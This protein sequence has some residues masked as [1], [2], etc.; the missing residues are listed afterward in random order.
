MTRSVAFADPGRWVPFDGERCTPFVTTRI[1][2]AHVHRYLATLDIARGKR[3]L[4]IACGEGYGAAML[5][6]N[7]AKAVT[8]ADLDAATVA[9][10]GEVYAHPG[11]DF[12]QADITCPLP[13]ADDAFDLVVSFET[14]E[15]VEAQAAFLDEV[16]RVLTPNGT[17]LCSTPDTR[18]SDPST[19]NPFHQKELTEDEFIELLSGRFAHVTRQYQGYVLGSVISGSGEEAHHWQRRGFLDYEEDGGAAQRF[20]ILACASN[21][22]ERFLPNGLLHD[23]AIV[24]TL[25][26]RIAELEARVA[27]LQKAEETI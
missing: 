21:A 9:R 14:I 10:A 26:K 17:F 4:D 24:S 15:H 19:P 7:G 23:G 27:E 13:F 16:A 25:N 11:L 20:Y 12:V 2:S 3:V 18:H 22:G 1:L 5:I 8:G 6:R